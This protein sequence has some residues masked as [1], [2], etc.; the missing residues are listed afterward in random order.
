MGQSHYYY[1]LDSIRSNNNSNAINYL[2]DFLHSLTPFKILP[3]I[4]ELKVS[5]VV[6]L[7]YNLDLKK[8]IFNSI[9]LII[10]SLHIN[11]ISAQIISEFCYS[12]LYIYHTLIL[13]QLILNYF[14]YLKEDNFLLL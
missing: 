13:Y 5:I 3:Y 11:F 10:K 4:L 8:R 2:N 1:S 12:K 7:L 14:L 6:M 9:C